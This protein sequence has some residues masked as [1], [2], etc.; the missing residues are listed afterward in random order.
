[1]ICCP[2]ATLAPSPLIRV[3]TCSS[4]VGLGLPLKRK[5]T[6]SP[7]S[8]WMDGTQA[9]GFCWVP[10]GLVRAGSGGF[11]AFALL[12]MSTTTNTESALPMPRVGLPV[13]PNISSAEPMIASREPTVVPG[14]VLPKIGS[15][16]ATGSVSG[17]PLSLS[18]VEIV[19]FWS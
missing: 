13:S 9:G 6:G 4:S 8:N 18:Y 19:F 5:P 3:A 12:S 16:S 14:R 2:A 15:S 11:G 10:C 7:F 1:M 17:P